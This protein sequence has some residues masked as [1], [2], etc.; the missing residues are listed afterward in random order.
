MLQVLSP[1]YWITFTCS[2]IKAVLVDALKKPSFWNTFKAVLLIWFLIPASV[3]VTAYKLAGL[4]G[5]EE[6]VRQLWQILL[7]TFGVVGILCLDALGKA[8]MALAMFLFTVI[9]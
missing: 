4:L 3:P 8:L 2:R 9:M 7:E 6:E 5:Y 1:W